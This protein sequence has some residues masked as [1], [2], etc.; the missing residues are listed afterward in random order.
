MQ[1]ITGTGVG[2][3][4]DQA[5]DCNAIAIRSWFMSSP[6]RLQKCGGDGHQRSD[7][8]GSLPRVVIKLGKKA[9]R[10]AEKSPGVI[11]KLHKEAL[12]EKKETVGRILL[13]DDDISEDPVEQH[14][15]RDEQ[16][17]EG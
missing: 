7:Q 11:K 10:V 9:S 15:G 13:D 16:S 14:Q 6:H 5:E 3:E 17:N 8:D 4:E 1:H 12:T 2:S